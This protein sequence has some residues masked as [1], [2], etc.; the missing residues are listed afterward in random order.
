MSFTFGGFNPKFVRGE[1]IT[2]I[3]LQPPQTKTIEMKE[4]LSSTSLLFSLDPILVIIRDYI[5]GASL[6]SIDLF[7]KTHIS[8]H[9]VYVLLSSIACCH[10]CTKHVFSIL[11]KCTIGKVEVTEFKTLPI[12]D[13]SSLVGKKFT[14][15]HMCKYYITMLTCRYVLVKN[16][17]S[18]N[19]MLEIMNPRD[20]SLT[21]SVRDSILPGGYWKSKEPFNIYRIAT[22]SSAPSS[23]ENIL[24]FSISMLKT[25]GVGI[26]RSKRRGLSGRIYAILASILISSVSYLHGEDVKRGLYYLRRAIDRNTYYRQLGITIAYP[27]FH[28]LRTDLNL[29]LSDMIFMSMNIFRDVCTGTLIVNSIYLNFLWKL[30]S[31]L[32]EKHCKII[33]RLENDEHKSPYMTVMYDRT[34][35]HVSLGVIPT[36][37]GLL[38]PAYSYSEKEVISYSILLYIIA[39]RFLWS[40]DREY[41]LEVL[42]D[43]QLDTDLAEIDKATYEYPIQHLL[44][45]I[46]GSHVLKIERAFVGR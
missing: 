36:D 15:E 13:T 26:L 29:R 44:T 43:I 35:Y 16:L 1:Q 46:G 34:T 22:M 28:A 32:L 9:E 2:K 8:L 19:Y 33:G 24:T 5:L 12:E 21:A 37:S 39:N 14:M 10:E 27:R 11:L 7:P 42:R 31:S 41:I 45:P 23:M 17:T 25:C 6:L 4:S 38:L 20:R 18:L 30:P 40:Y 3:T